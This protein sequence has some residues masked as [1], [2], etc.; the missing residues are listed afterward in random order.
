[1]RPASSLFRRFFW[2]A[3]LPAALTLLALDIYLR[4]FPFSAEIRAEI[5]LGLLVMLL[6]AIIFAIIA[7]SV[8]A[9]SLN[10]RVGRIRSFAENLVHS[11]RFAR[12]PLPE[13][14]AAEDELGALAR[15]LSRAAAEW[16]GLV[17]RLG[18]ESAHRE[19]ILKSMVEGVLAV[20]N[21][22]G[23]IFCN[24]SFARLVGATLPLPAQTSLLDLARDPSLTQMLSHVLATRQ[25]LKQTLYLAAADGRV[26][27]VQAA[28][29]TETAQ[30]GAIA[31]LHDITGLERLERIRKDFV[32][33]VSHELRTPLTAIQGYAESLLD[34]AL[35][36]PGDA[37]KFVEVILSHAVRL[38]NIASD[39]L[40]LSEIESGRPQPELQP[41]SIDAAI[42]NALR[43]VE[44]EARLRQVS[45][46]R[47][48]AAEAQI[49]GVRVHL[50]QALINLLNNAIKFNRPGGKVRVEASML[51]KD[52]I[53]VTVVDN[54]IGI[55]SEDLSRI[56]ERFYRVDKA[57]S[58]EVGGTGLG[59]SIVKHLVERMGGTVKVDSLL[60]EGSTF[61][62]TLPGR[63]NNPPL[64]NKAPLEV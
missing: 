2:S 20:D 5:H 18:V 35:E 28:P 44:S 45:L 63:R 49:F 10:R 64:E 34:G 39:L 60:G 25:P 47:G 53:A 27:E 62:V 1:M 57:R 33:N 58:R 29:L 51:G 23:V 55:P 52:R 41:L 13:G 50:E 21:D 12:N 59:L 26:F 42:E 22:L 11:R 17:E 24:D 61:T 4:A 7:A 30:A 43:A 36:N 37:R 46:E 38:N 16:E 19:A 15:E 48:E 56:F 54:G 32:A 8:G 6:V 40:A 31:I 14:A 9:R 3:F